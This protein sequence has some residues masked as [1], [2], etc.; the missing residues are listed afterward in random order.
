MTSISLPF[1]L[2]KTKN[3]AR[4]GGKN[5]SQALGCQSLRSARKQASALSAVSAPLS[6]M[7][8]LV[9]LV[10]RVVTFAR[11]TRSRTW[12][13]GC[14]IAKRKTSLAQRR[15]QNSKKK[16]N[17]ASVDRTQYLQITRPFGR[18]EPKFA[19]GADCFSLALSQVS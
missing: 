16:V 11:I 6:D 15:K 13:I 5:C 7:R 14:P 4:V 19:A 18:I 17:V 2:I 12:L 1:N 8:P 3:G 9:L 10:I